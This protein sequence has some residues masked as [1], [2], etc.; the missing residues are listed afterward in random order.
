MTAGIL[1]KGHQCR[2][3]SQRGDR[4]RPC[5]MQCGGRMRGSGYNLKK[6]SFRLD[7]KEKCFPHEDSRSA[8]QVVWRDCTVSVFGGF[9][10]P[11]GHSPEQPV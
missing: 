1:T 6:D 11:P 8:E 10:D 5:N 3:G 9:Q 4:A 2:W 7:V